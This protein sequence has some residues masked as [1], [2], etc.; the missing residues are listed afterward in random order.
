MKDFDSLLSSQKGEDITLAS[1]QTSYRLYI[2][3]GLLTSFTKVWVGD[4]E[5]RSHLYR[6]KNTNGSEKIF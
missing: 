5:E 3:A 1:S 2:V 4:R 6:T